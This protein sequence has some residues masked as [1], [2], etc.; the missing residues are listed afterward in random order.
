MLTLTNL[1]R[2]L[3]GA[4]L[5]AIVA[6]LL[7]N[8]SISHLESKQAKALDT[9][10]TELENKCTADK[11][12]TE[13]IS[14]DYQS[15]INQLNGQLASLRMRMPSVCIPVITGQANGSH[16]SS[17]A[18]QH[19]GQNGGITS[20]ALYGFSGECETYRLRLIGLQ[21]FVNKVWAQNDGH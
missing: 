16:A 2:W 4:V 13:D 17:T 10:K 19:G 3:P 7:H 9:Q 11:K 14:S 1:F 8:W 18:G 12:I 15:K 5:T 20:D 21:N 6:L